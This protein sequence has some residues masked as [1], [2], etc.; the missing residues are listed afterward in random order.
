MTTL[1]QVHYESTPNPQSL[2]YV[3]SQNVVDEIAQFSNLVEARSSPLANKIFGFP[4]CA[5]ILIGPNFVTVTKQEWVD[6]DILADPL[7]EL[8]KEHLDLNEPILAPR[9]HAADDR[10]AVNSAADDSPVVARIKQLLRDEIRPAV[11]MDGGDVHFEK[12]SEG[13]LY[14]SL[15]GACSGC[16]SAAMTLKEGIERRVKEWVPEVSEVLN[17][18]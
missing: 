7:A 16:P 1:I 17:W 2:K 10:T 8:I 4:W 18:P 11:S 5:G 3:F 9:T 13:K 15:H 6:W 12:F 14:L